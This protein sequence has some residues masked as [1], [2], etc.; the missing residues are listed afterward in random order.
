MLLVCSAPNFNSCS[1]SPPR[2]NTNGT[3]YQSNT[4]EHSL[5]F[6]TTRIA[7]Y[8]TLSGTEN[9]I[10]IL[11]FSFF[12]YA[13]IPKRPSVHQLSPIEPQQHNQRYSHNPPCMLRY[14]LRYLTCFGPRKC[15]GSTLPLAEWSVATKA[16]TNF[17]AC[18]G[19]PR[20]S[21]AET[22]RSTTLV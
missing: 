1:P 14:T 12:S 2:P 11:L 15:A 21:P 9:I 20:P 17:S 16:Q 22:I 3:R 19:A 5:Q 4:S 13:S 8:D 6:Q 10:L 18:A 7:R